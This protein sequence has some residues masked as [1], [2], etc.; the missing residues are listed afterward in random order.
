MASR[1]TYIDSGVLIAAFQGESQVHAAAMEILDDP[2]R[3]ILDDPAPFVPLV[4]LPQIIRPHQPDKPQV[5]TFAHDVSQGLGRIPR[6]TPH[7]VVANM[8]AGVIQQLSAG[9]KPVFEVL[10]G[11]VF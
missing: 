5:R 3:D 6:A 11:A 9:S 1:R 8:H 10:R 4:E 7:L 2:D